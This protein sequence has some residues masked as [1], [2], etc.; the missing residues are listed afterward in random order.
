MPQ[1]RE[2]ASM[3]TKCMPQMPPPMQPPPAT[4][5]AIRPLGLAAEDTRSEVDSATVAARMAMNTE[6]PT[7]PGL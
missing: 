6:R 4:S 1:G 3:P 2:K 7:S 5:Q